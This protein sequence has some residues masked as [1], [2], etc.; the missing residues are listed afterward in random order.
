M[1]HLIRPADVGIRDV[2]TRREPLEI[3]GFIRDHLAETGGGD[4]PQKRVVVSFMH[5]GKSSQPIDFSLQSSGTKKVFNLGPDWWRLAN[6]P[7]TIFADEVSASLHPRL[8]DS[9]IRTF[10][11]APND[12]V[13]SQL[14]FATHDTGLLESRDGLPPA[15]RRDQ[16]YFTKK[17]S[18]GASELYSLT[19]FKDSARSVHNIRK[20]Y[21]SGLYGAIPSVEKLLL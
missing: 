10:N 12:R 6:E 18:Q 15:L 16:V 20:R 9:L 2:Q 4:L 3:P 19:E 14:I 8:L 5:E 13:R 11:D 21:L 7:V 17:D 1:R